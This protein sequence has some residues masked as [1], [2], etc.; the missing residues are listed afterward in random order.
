MSSL[1]QPAYESPK[2]KAQVLLTAD[3][4]PG[5]SEKLN[6]ISGVPDVCLIYWRG[7]EKDQEAVTITMCKLRFS[8]K[9]SGLEKTLCC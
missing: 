4:T 5:V 3:C 2:V 8:F 9:T 1:L 6:Y 7:E